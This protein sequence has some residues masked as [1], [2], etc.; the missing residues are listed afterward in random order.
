MRAQEK[1]SNHF[2]KYE[3]DENYRMYINRPLGF[4][5]AYINTYVGS[6]TKTGLAPLFYLCANKIK[7][8]VTVIIT[9]LKNSKKLN[10]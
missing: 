4:F 1:Y 3:T 8:C 10:S 6:D 9:V 7:Y 5:N 2:R